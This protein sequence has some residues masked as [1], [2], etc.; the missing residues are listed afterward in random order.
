M[1]G[2]SFKQSLTDSSLWN[3]AQQESLQK[4]VNNQ[5]CRKRR[6]ATVIHGS[7]EARVSWSTVTHDNQLITIISW[8]K[9]AGRSPRFV[10]QLVIA[11]R[12]PS[13]DLWWQ[14]TMIGPNKHASMSG[15]RRNRY[16]S[17]RLIAPRILYLI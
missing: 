16:R 11:T 1:S 3:I 4:L 9:D 12:Q 13:P 7:S 17:E 10:E 2:A 15:L 8:L 5:V 14:I 6:G